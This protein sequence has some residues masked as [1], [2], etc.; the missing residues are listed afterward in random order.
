[1]LAID[2]TLDPSRFLPRR[3]RRGRCALDLGVVLLGC[4]YGRDGFSSELGLKEID[5]GLIVREGSMWVI[6]RE[7]CEVQICRWWRSD[8]ASG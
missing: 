6:V 4:I 8:G 2:R 5:R 3:D 7:L 1:M